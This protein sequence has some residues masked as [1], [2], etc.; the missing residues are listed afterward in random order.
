MNVVIDNGYY[1]TV[2]Y[3]YPN[4]HSFRSKVQQSNSPIKF[5]NTHKIIYNNTHYLVGEGA[6]NIDINLNKSNSLLHLITTLTGLGL[7]GSNSYN[8]IAN[9][10]LNL[11]TKESKQSFESYLKNISWF[12]Y[13]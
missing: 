2:S 1:S 5:S 7:F 13:L 3:L 11:Y 10:P 9:L 12:M 8:L 6:E 4:I